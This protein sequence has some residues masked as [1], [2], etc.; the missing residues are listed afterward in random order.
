VGGRK[1]MTELKH[2][3]F[4]SQFCSCH[5]LC[6]LSL[7]LNEI[8]NIQTNVEFNQI[9][10]VKTLNPVCDGCL[11][12]AFINKGCPSLFRRPLKSRSN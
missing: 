8:E 1:M 3:G 2:V 12:L 7:L 4:V 5:Q 10:P 6:G 9:T 11:A